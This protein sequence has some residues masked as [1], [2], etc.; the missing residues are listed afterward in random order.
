MKLHELDLC[1]GPRDLHQPYASVHR[2]S[3]SA[4]ESCSPAHARVSE[5]L[6]APHRLEAQHR[7][8]PRRRG[9]QVIH[10]DIDVV[11]AHICDRESVARVRPTVPVR[12]CLC[13][14]DG[15]HRHAV[16]VVPE[17]TLALMNVHLLLHVVVCR[18]ESLRAL[19]RAVYH[20]QAPQNHPHHQRQHCQRQAGAAL[21]RLGR[22][23]GVNVSRATREQ[24][25]YCEGSRPLRASSTSVLHSLPARGIFLE[26][27]KRSA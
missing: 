5:M 18:G 23:H 7:L 3:F 1:V 21:W 24:D 2:C 10:H 15:A 19:Q 4:V 6:E 9:F 14:R 22:G 11:H 8:V 26:V 27:R 20:M 25:R 17:S 13:R 16:V 12:A